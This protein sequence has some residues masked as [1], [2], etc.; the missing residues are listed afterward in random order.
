MKVFNHLQT[1]FVHII[2]Q[3]LQLIN[4]WNKAKLL[5]LSKKNIFVPRNRY[6]QCTKSLESLEY[7]QLWIQKEPEND[8]VTKEIIKVFRASRN[9]YG[10]RKIK[11]DLEK[12]ELI[13]PRRRIGRIMK[14]EGLISS[15]TVAQF[16]PFKVKVNEE[17]VKNILN[18]A[19]NHQT[20]LAV[21]V[22]D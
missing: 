6:Q 4:G 5:A 22:S 21:V 18:S 8:S 13:V 19:F 9:N 20:E 1:L 7:L 15:D 3:L 11:I 12:K 14:V 10:T 16:K 17:P 2:I